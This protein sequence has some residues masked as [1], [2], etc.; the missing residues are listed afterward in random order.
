MRSQNE[1]PALDTLKASQES[2]NTILRRAVGLFDS[3]RADL[4]DEVIEACNRVDYT[5]YRIAVFGPFNYG[6]STLLNAL[7]GEKTLPMDLVPT[8]GAAIIVKY[9]PETKT[10]VT[11]IDG[12]VTQQAGTSALQDFAILNEH[13]QMRDDVAA[14]E[15]YCPHP[16]LKLGID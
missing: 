4:K 13:R 2:L 1:E 7:L 9:G 8:T 10:C 6:K 16:L 14:V 5:S 15:V 3:N 11:H 12:T